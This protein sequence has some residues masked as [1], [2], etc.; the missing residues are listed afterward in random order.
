MDDQPDK[1]QIEPTTE[2]SNLSPTS[3]YV[4]PVFQVGDRVRHRAS[5]KVAVVTAR[6][7]ACVKHPPLALCALKLDRTECQMEP[8]GRYSLSFDFGDD[9][10]LEGVEGF[11][12]E[13]VEVD[14]ET[15]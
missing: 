5:G 10:E 11:L 6:L 4:A 12:L 14:T 15:T 3:G 2:S 9:N 13:R 7:F 1:T 8:T